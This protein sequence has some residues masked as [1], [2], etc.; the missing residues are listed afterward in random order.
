MGYERGV[1]AGVIA[2]WGVGFRIGNS[3][4]PRQPGGFLEVESR[5]WGRNAGLTRR[6]AGAPIDSNANTASSKKT[7]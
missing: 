5:D 6:F 4:R 1:E 2:T 3:A 7:A